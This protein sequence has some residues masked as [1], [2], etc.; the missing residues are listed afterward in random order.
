MDIKIHLDGKI[1][2]PPN[3]HVD[4]ANENVGFGIHGT[5]EEFLL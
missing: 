5:Q 4:F 1:E 3:V 2:D